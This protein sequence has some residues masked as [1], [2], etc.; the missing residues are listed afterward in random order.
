MLMKWC[1]T[2]L[3]CYRWDQIQMVTLA[4]CNINLNKTLNKIAT[5]LCI[6]LL[7][8]LIASNHISILKSHSGQSHHSVGFQSNTVI[9]EA[10]LKITFLL[11]IKQGVG[12][13]CRTEKKILCCPWGRDK[14]VVFCN[15]FLV[16][17]QLFH[18]MTAK[19]PEK[20]LT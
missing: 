5:E 20:S 11:M 1:L 17:L 19:M 2:I 12:T 9:E 3:C 7:M 15:S 6:P 8:A 13:N 4:R 14:Q 16:G 10:I 18:S